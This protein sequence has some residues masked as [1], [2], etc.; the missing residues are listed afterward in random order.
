MRLYVRSWSTS[1]AL[2]V[3]GEQVAHDPQR[4]LGLLVDER[5]RLR[6]SFAFASIDFQRRCRKSRSRSM[7]SA[8]APSAAVRTITPPCFGACS[9]RIAFR[10]LRSSS[11]SRR[12]TPSPSPCGT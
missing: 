9:L 7:S 10:R 3:T 2:E 11:S 12:E 1:S 6:G 5:R 4:Q 8:E